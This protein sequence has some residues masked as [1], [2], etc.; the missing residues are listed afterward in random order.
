MFG[1]TVAIPLIL[2]KPLGLEGQPAQLGLLIGTMFFVSGIA[3][4]LQTTLGNRLPI[5]Q[6]GTFSFLAP[7][8]AICSVAALKGVGWEVRMEHM[9]GAI[10]AGSF[11]QILIGYSGLV[12]KMLRFIG[13]ITIAP[14]I[15]LIGLSLF[16]F[17]A[18]SGRHPLANWWL[19]DIPDHSLFAISAH[20]APVFLSSFQYS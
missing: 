1:S 13:P 11:F 3:T 15:A 2:A 14:T 20:Q 5:V 9:Q 12:G 19:D 10:I 6:G 16:K 4:L 18:P 17:G 7:A 8:F